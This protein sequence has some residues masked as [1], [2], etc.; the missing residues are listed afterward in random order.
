MPEPTERRHHLVGD[1]E[2]VEF[3]AHLLRAAVVPGRG[4]DHTA[5]PEDRLGEERRHVL[6]AQLEDLRF[7]LLHELVAERLQRHTTGSSVRIGRRDVV[8]EVGREVEAGLVRGPL[9]QRHREV[10]TPVVRLPPGD[11]ELLV[12]FAEPL[13][14]EVERAGGR[15]DGLRSAGPVEHVVQRGGGEF[16]ELRR[17]LGGRR[18][19]RVDERVEEGKPIR[20]FGQGL[21]HL[22]VAVPDVHAPQAADT[23]EIALAVSVVDVRAFSFG[24]DEGAVLLESRKLGPGVQEVVLV[25]VPE[26]LTVG[27][28]EARP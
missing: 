28:V 21:S 5:G 18:V 3:P 9:A 7:E 6:G 27:I 1:V 10:C 23:V 24:N 2:D 12:G 25:L 14:V 26:F 8:H 22:P 11:E 4:N 19:R 16:G 15:F 13:E 17:Q 20:L